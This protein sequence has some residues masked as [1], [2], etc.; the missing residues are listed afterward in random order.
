M[1]KK[2]PSPRRNWN[3]RPAE[4]SDKEQVDQLLQKSYS[5]LLP[6][7][8]DDHLLQQA[9]PKITVARDELLTCG[10][11][12][13][14]EDSDDN[15][16]RIVGCGGFTLQSPTP[17]NGND[18]NPQDTPHLRHFATDP[19]YARQGIAS[20]IWQR[21]WQDLCQHFDS[22]PPTM[23]VFSTL[24]A[25]SFYASLGFRAVKEVRIPLGEGC[26]FP[27]ILMRRDVKTESV[28]DNDA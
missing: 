16:P 2:M 4:P 7:D 27:A 25:E 12:Y 13:V 6:N 28:E 19:D 15:P 18:S 3:V 17:S 9:L 22:Q 14:V 24:T 11:W 10:T 1:S 8:Y 26:E 21:T 20:A 23:E 5:R